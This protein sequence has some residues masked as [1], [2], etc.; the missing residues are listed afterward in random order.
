MSKIKKKRGLVIALDVD[1]V[2]KAVKIACELKSAKGT[3]S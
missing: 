2:S 1:D 3:L